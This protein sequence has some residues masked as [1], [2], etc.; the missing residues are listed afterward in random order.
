MTRYERT[1]PGQIAYLSDSSLPSAATGIVLGPLGP[2]A[3]AVQQMALAY[4]RSHN[5]EAVK[6][7]GIVGFALGLFVIAIAWFTWPRKS[8]PEAPNPA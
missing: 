4:G 5:D 1:A 6:I 2:F 3:F 7:P 8:A